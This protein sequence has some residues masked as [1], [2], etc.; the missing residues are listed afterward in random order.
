MFF[1]LYTFIYSNKDRLGLSSL[2]KD[3]FLSLNKK[4]KQAEKFKRYRIVILFYLRLCTNIY[5]FTFIHTDKKVMGDKLKKNCKI[6]ER[7]LLM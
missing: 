5:F 1:T 4:L 2:K 7:K 3:L 6:E